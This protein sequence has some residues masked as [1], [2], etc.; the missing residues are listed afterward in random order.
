MNIFNIDLNPY[1]NL[2]RLFK[3]L[4]D[5]ITTYNFV[6][7]D[8]IFVLFWYITWFFFTVSFFIVHMLLPSWRENV[9][10]YEP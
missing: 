9:H 10:V 7:S 3:N 8:E 1:W 2:L 4:Y 6:W 5:F